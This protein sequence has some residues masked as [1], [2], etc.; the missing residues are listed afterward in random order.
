[1]RVFDNTTQSLFV[2]DPR[3]GD[4]REITRHAEDDSH[5]P[6]GWLADGRAVV[7]TDEDSDHLWLGALNVGTG[8]YETID[9]PD[10]DVELA[11]SSAD[12]RTQI[13]SVNEDGYSTLR[14]RIGSG[15][16][17]ERRLDG[18]ACEDLVISPDGSR[19]AF[20]RLSPIEPW[21]VWTLDTA[22]GDA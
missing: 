1:M 18:A 4:A 10:W 16:I 13:W 21:Q 22:T 11:A 8:A 2:V 14:W 6:A 17:R 12:G 19:A 5:I 15:P 20:T 3:G 7:I 9:R